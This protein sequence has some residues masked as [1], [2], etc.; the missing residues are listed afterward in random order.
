MVKEVRRELRPSAFAV[1]ARCKGVAAA[2]QTRQRRLHDV[3]YTRPT[4][5]G[6]SLPGGALR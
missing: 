6:G 1:E 2:A 5:V 3:L 4:L